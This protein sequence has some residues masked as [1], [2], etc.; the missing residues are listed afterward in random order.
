MR[1]EKWTKDTYRKATVEELSALHDEAQQG[2][3]YTTKLKVAV[4]CMIWEGRLE[5]IKKELKR[6]T[7]TNDSH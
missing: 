5:E 2:W 7:P 3:S 6:R 4:A 1:L